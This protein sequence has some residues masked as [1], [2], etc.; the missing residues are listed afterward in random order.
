MVRI[1]RGQRRTGKDLR[2]AKVSMEW[3]MIRGVKRIIRESV[4]GME[5]MEQVEWADDVVYG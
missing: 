4:G 1:V 5:P 3:K 2:E